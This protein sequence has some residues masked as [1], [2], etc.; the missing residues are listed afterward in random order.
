MPT[1]IE[2][3]RG[4]LLLPTLDVPLALAPAPAGV[5]GLNP[6]VE[7]SNDARPVPIG[8]GRQRA[9]QGLPEFNGEPIRFDATGTLRVG[10]EVPA[11]N[12]HALALYAIA[13]A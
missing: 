12:R 5:I 10:G 6:R 9:P 1:R 11:T 4:P 3:A 8:R 2:R 7:R 13:Q